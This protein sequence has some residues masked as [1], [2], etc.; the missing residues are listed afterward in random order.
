MHLIRHKS[1]AEYWAR[2]GHFDHLAK[3]LELTPADR[4]MAW[5]EA[6]R[7]EHFKEWPVPVYHFLKDPYYVGETINVRPMIGEFLADFWE[8]SAG[9]QVFVFIAGIGAGKSFSASLSLVYGL[10]QLSCLR[11]PAK[12]LSGFP[13]C[14][15]SDDAP[16]VFMNAS[17]AGAVQSGK[18]VYGEAFERVQKSPYFIRHFQPYQ[19]KGLA[20]DTEIATPAG[21]TTMGALREG[22]TIFGGDGSPC[23]VTS[24]FAPRELDCYRV[25]LADGSSVVADGDHRWT[26]WDRDCNAER[27]VDTRALACAAGRSRTRYMLPSTPPLSGLPDADLVIAPYALGAW[28]G[29]GTSSGAG[30]TSADEE[31]AEHLAAVGEPVRDLRSSGRSYAWTWAGTRAGPREGKFVARLR[32]L[33]VLD[34]KHVP[35]EYLRGSAEQRLALLQGLMDTDGSVYFTHGESSRCEFTSVN[36]RLARDVLALTR[37]LGIRSKLAT[38]SAML[39][40]VDCGPRWRV[41]F[42]TGL[43]VF[44]LA[45]KLTRIVEDRRER[46]V[47]VVGVEAVDPVATRCIAVDSDSATFLAGRDLIVTHN[48]SELE[49]PNRIRLSPGSSNFRTALGWNVFGFVVDEAAFGVGSGADGGD[50]IDHVKEL[51]GALDTRRRS[52]FGTLGFGGLFT[53]P[54]SEY[55]F[56]EVMGGEDGGVSTMVRRT[57]TWDAQDQVKK[58]A[59]VFLLDRHPDVTKVLDT[60]L[61]YVGPGV[62]QR[63][64]GTIVRWQSSEPAEDNNGPVAPATAAA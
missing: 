54:G 15:L 25:S 53:S 30:F 19:G 7:D 58:G 2:W 41:T 60:H 8:P 34:D 49:F 29:D 32:A 21:W 4:H 37:S 14:S 20:L 45:R 46:R 36:E 40:G 24:A 28:L 5:Q 56:V 55:A 48:S 64:D 44:K 33:G 57:T 26:V 10:Y 6:T 27:V 3:Q 63:P 59:D 42:S 47:G 35:V 51:F 61:V 23:R 18:I 43:P 39:N 16:I 13:G 1:P 50:R 9:F 31:I 17:A 12:Y 38:G 22:D 11:T 52:R 62:A